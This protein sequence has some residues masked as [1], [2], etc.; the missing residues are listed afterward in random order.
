[1]LLLHVLAITCL[2][3]VPRWWSRKSLA[4]V[5]VYHDSQISIQRYYEIRIF[6]VHQKRCF[7]SCNFAMDTARV[8]L[9]VCI[10]SKCSHFMTVAHN[11]ELDSCE[12]LFTCSIIT[13]ANMKSKAN[14]RTSL[15]YCGLRVFV[16][17]FSGA[18]VKMWKS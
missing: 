7:A 3:L 11:K 1:M 10:T 9:Y 13:L 16:V 5:H 18:R 4:K 12:P 17:L 2:L 8:L 15:G 6:N 14:S